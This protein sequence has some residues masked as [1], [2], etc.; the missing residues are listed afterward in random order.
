[1]TGRS[2]RLRAARPAGARQ[3][4]GLEIRAFAPV[5]AARLRMLN[6]LERF[7]LKEW[8]RWSPQTSHVLLG[9]EARISIG[10]AT[11]RDPDFVE[12]P[13]RL[14]EKTPRAELAESIRAGTPAERLAGA[15]PLVGE[16]DSTTH[17]SVVDRDGLAV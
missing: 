14:T 3:F 17:F 15:I 2:G 6:T 16:G 13:A 7:P 12:I 1:M 4:R 11:W 9:Q 10:P 5:L 8:G